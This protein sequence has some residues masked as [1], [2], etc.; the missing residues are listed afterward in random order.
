M[1][2]SYRV[3]GAT[4]DEA[5]EAAK[6]QARVEGWILRTVAGARAATDSGLWIVTLAAVRA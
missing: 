1:R 6:V 4:S 3:A 2:I 5:I